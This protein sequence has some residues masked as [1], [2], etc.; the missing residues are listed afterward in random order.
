MTAEAFMNLIQGMSVS[1]RKRLIGLI[2]DSLSH[3]NDEHEKIYN[4]MDFAG[5]GNDPSGGEEAIR[6]IN[7]MRDEWD[8]PRDV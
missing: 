2:V 5:I 8:A 3:P 6:L 1:E 7:E 4:V